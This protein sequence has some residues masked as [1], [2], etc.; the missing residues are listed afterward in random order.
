MDRLNTYC[1]TE[2]VVVFV[3]VYFSSPM[4]ILYQIRLYLKEIT[5]FD[6]RFN[7]C[8]FLVLA[9][10]K[11]AVIFLDFASYQLTTFLD[12]ADNLS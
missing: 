1:T 2:I 6:F 7:H 5:I 10:E 3:S 12:Y 11:S 4:T 8:F 9:T